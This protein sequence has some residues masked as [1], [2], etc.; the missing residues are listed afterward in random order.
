MRTPDEG[1]ATSDTAVAD[2]AQ[3]NSRV[4]P[5]QMQS[6]LSA[7]AE[8]SG[9]TGHRASREEGGVSLRGGDAESRAREGDRFITYWSEKGT[10][11]PVKWLFFNDALFQ[12]SGSDFLAALALI[13]AAVNLVF[14][15]VVGCCGRDSDG[16]LRPGKHNNAHSI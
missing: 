7:A 1:V 3:E 8:G 4:V 11:R 6:F 10:N 15:S 5:G 9:V 16:G 12:A 13:A 2:L 14:L